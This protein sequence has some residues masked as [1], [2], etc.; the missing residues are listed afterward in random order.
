MNLFERKTIILIALWWSGLL[1]SLICLSFGL[2]LFAI[3]ISF[4]AAF[5]R[6]A[7]PKKKSYLSRKEGF[8]VHIG[9]LLLF[10]FLLQ[11]ELAYKIMATVSEREYPVTFFGGIVLLFSAL[12]LYEYRWF[13]NVPQGDIHDY[14][15]Q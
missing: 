4:F 10:I 15:N 5:V 14:Y 13:S 9:T 1:L 12:V 8:L 3:Y 11:S 7:L 6:M 2:V